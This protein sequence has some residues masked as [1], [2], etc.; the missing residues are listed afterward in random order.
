[1]VLVLALCWVLITVTQDTIMIFIRTFIRIRSAFEHYSM[2]IVLLQQEDM[3]PAA[4]GVSRRSKRAQSDSSGRLVIGG[5]GVVLILTS[6]RQCCVYRS[7]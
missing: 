2:C 4:L 6:I 1:M 5:A 7:G 3:V